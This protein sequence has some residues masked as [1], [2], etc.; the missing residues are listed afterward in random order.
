MK[1][2][3]VYR[4]DGG[5]SII[6]PAPKSK[7][8]DETEEQ[9]LARVFIRSMQPQYDKHGNQVNLLVGCEYD[10]IE[11]SELPQTREDRSA[12]VGKKGKGI[13]ID[14]V[15][16]DKLRAEKAIREEVEEI[17][18]ISLWSQA[19]AALKAR[20]KLPADYKKAEA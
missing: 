20:G 4:E 7:R 13:S 14:Q 3:V 8:L 5:V 19:I 10:D 2:R 9:W 18:R 16:A 1:V 17:K 11:D 15:K 6:H 12:W